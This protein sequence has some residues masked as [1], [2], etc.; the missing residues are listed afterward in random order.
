MFIGA[1][2]T[3]AKIWKHLKYSY[4]EMQFNLKREENLALCGNMDEPGGHYIISQSQRT[5]C[6]IPCML[7]YKIIKYIKTEG[8]RMVAR[9]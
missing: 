4:S 9:S 7:G 1:L 3:V 2:F 6:I 5:N 8:R